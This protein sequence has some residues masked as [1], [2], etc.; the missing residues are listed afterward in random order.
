MRKVC[1]LLWKTNKK[2]AVSHTEFP[3]TRDLPRYYLTSF[4]H[5]IFEYA[6]NPTHGS[7]TADLENVFIE[8]DATAFPV[9]KPPNSFIAFEYRVAE[10]SGRLEY[11]N[12][13]RERVSEGLF[14][15]SLTYHLR[16]G[17]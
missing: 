5:L 13:T 17:L 14:C 7:A 8:S 10:A 3:H 2:T 11:P 15:G 12:P 1:V 6:I 4:E 16:I 9:F